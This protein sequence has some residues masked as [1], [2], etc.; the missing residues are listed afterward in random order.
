M[1]DG[2]SLFS[3]SSSVIRR[4]NYRL[5]TVKSPFICIGGCATLMIISKR[6]TLTVFLGVVGILG[7]VLGWVHFLGVVRVLGIVLGGVHFLGVV[8][9]LGIVLHV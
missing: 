4:N 9:V 7:I 3:S 8:G 2:S 1:Y 6:L 5:S